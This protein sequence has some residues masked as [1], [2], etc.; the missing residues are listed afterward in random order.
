[1]KVVI[2]TDFGSFRLSPKAVKMLMEKKG[3]PCYVYFISYI[4]DALYS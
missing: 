4:E 1:M 3:L 2:N